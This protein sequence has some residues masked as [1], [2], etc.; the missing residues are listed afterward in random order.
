MMI[1]SIFAPRL[2]QLEL[3][4]QAKRLSQG[5]PEIAIRYCGYTVTLEHQE[6]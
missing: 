5:K 1:N 4:N 3:Y 6:M 2:R